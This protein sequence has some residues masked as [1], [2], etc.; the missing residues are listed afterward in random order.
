MY[1]DYVPALNA[2]LNAETDRTC[3]NWDD[4]VVWFFQMNTDKKMSSMSTIASLFVNVNRPN[5]FRIDVELLQPYFFKFLISQQTLEENKFVEGEHFIKD[6]E[7]LRITF[8]TMTKLILQKGD[9]ELNQAFEFI[10]KMFHIYRR[11]V[12]ATGK[13]S[14]LYTHWT[15]IERVSEF[16]ATMKPHEKASTFTIMDA[17]PRVFSIVKG[18]QKSINNRLNKIENDEKYIKCGHFRVYETVMHDIDIELSIIRQY[19]KTTIV[20]P[21][22]KSQIGQLDANGD[23]IKLISKTKTNMHL[24]K[25]QILIDS[26]QDEYT[27]ANLAAHIDEIR[28]SLQLGITL[29]DPKKIKTQTLKTIKN[30]Q[31]DIE[32]F[33][34]TNGQYIDEFQSLELTPWIDDIAIVDQNAIAVAPKAET[35]KKVAPISQKKTPAA[36]KKVAPVSQKKTPAAPKKTAKAPKK[37]SEV[38]KKTTESTLAVVDKES[39]AFESDEDDNADADDESDFDESDFDDS[40]DEDDKKIVS[41]GRTQS[42]VSIRKVDA[43]SSVMD[44][45]DSEDEGYAS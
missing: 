8:S 43:V 5:Y 45:I 41:R 11:Y 23:A 15:L 18:S 27:P 40:E 34:R 25:T 36:P 12:F 42:C 6:E 20:D 30:N 44:E 10:D 1:V 3:K 35:P 22:R 33:K 2:F 24:L 31:T 16:T 4:V 9:D 13:K 32:I 14:K 7:G 19:L 26:Q 28:K 17:Q 39:Y 37:T 29:I 21:Y 38:S